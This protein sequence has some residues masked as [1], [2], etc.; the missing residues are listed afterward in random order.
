MV[1]PRAQRAPVAPRAVD[2]EKHRAAFDPGADLDLRIGALWELRGASAWTKLDGRTLAEHL[3]ELLNED[4]VVG[5]EAHEA[6]LGLDVP[7]GEPVR[8]LA[9]LVDARGRLSVA[10]KPLDAVA[11]S[12]AA[13]RVVALAKIGALAPS[14]GA[15]VLQWPKTAAG[16]DLVIERA[17]H[18][19]MP[20]ASLRVRGDEALV[21]SLRDAALKLPMP[22]RQLRFRRQGD[23]FTVADVYAEGHVRIGAA[24]L[25]PGA[26]KALTNGTRID[27]AG[28]GNIAATTLTVR[29]VPRLERAGGLTVRFRDQGRRAER[30]AVG[31]ALWLGPAVDDD[32]ATPTRARLVATPKGAVLVSAVAL[33]QARGAVVVGTVGVRFEGE[34]VLLLDN[35]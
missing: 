34:D 17:P 3:G 8:D 4:L 23:G 32:V 29:F 16:H 31:E 19:Q 18:A 33:S 1:Y 30:L 20:A 5:S 10:G 11:G 35:P 13:A 14:S 6:L 21:G 25:R 12:A 2:L 28:S 27:V 26:P 7:G 9:V 24:A 22:Q 15:P